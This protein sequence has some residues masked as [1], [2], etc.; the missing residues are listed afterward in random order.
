MTLLSFDVLLYVYLTPL[1]NPVWTKLTWI[2]FK[3]SVY[4][5]WMLAL[6]VGSYLL[7]GCPEML[8]NSY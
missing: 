5:A 6:Y 8:V 1:F 4:T 7:T 2:T 3:R